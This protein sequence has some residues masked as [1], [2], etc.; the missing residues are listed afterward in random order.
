MQNLDSKQKEIKL[1]EKK[2]QLKQI[3][4]LSTAMLHPIL[5]DNEIKCIHGGVVQLKS[6]LGKSIQDKIG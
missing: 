3:K 1:K 5:E 2:T 4:P 6:N